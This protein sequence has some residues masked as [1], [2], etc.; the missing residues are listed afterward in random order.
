MDPEKQLPKA[1]ALDKLVL[2]C[3]RKL[4]NGWQQGYNLLLNGIYWGYNPF[5]NHLLT[6]DSW[7]IQVALTKIRVQHFKSMTPSKGTQ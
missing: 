4:A 3:P 6:A 7:D 2:G 5:T 1:P